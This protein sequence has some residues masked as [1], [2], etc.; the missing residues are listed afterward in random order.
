[1]SGTQTTLQRV[2]FRNNVLKLLFGATE[3]SCLTPHP[4]KVFEQVSC[5][6]FTHVIQSKKVVSTS[7]VL[8]WLGWTLEPASLFLEPPAIS[9]Q[10]RTSTA[11]KAMASFGA[12]SALPSPTTC[13]ALSWRGGCGGGGGRAGSR[14]RWSWRRKISRCRRLWFYTM[15]KCDKMINMW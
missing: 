5:L 13:R 1:M 15:I 10:R 2:G 6:V 4:K 12:P 9:A 8:C 7:Q 14:R 11:P 3:S